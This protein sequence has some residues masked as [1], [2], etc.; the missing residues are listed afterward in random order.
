M[1]DG[2][3]LHLAALR[4][5]IIFKFHTVLWGYPA[6]LRVYCV[7]SYDRVNSFSKND[8]PS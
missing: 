1:E 5:T 6:A 4:F 2:S 3:P 8:T 7:S